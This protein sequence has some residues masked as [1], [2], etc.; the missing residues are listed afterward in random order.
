MTVIVRPIISSEKR[1]PRFASG[2]DNCTQERKDTSMSNNKI[3]SPKMPVGTMWFYMRG[4]YSE[5]ETEEKLDQI[6]EQFGFSGKREDEDLLVE[7]G[8]DPGKSREYITDEELE[9]EEIEDLMLMVDN[10]GILSDII[11]WRCEWCFEGRITTIDML[12]ECEEYLNN[13]EDMGTNWPGDFSE[14]F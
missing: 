4:N 11:F 6:M 14:Y 1:I 8:L 2:Q 12:Q 10:E 7:L 3:N 5:D 9:D 13:W